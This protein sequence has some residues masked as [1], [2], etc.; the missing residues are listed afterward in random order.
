MRVKNI[1]S[2]GWL[3]QLGSEGDGSTTSL[4]QTGSGSNVPDFALRMRPQK[5][6]CSSQSPLPPPS[7][8]PPWCPIT[9]NAAGN[10][11]RRK[12]T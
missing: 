10:C 6:P 3:A 8:R 7:G 5:V 12:Q 1:P 4:S 9:A 2:R 11:L